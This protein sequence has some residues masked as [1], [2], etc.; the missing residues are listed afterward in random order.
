MIRKDRHLEITN[1][2]TGEI[3]IFEW[4]DPLSLRM[5]YQEVASL[6]TA[7]G[8]AKERLLRAMDETLGDEDEFNFGDGYTMKRIVSFTTKYPREV[9]AKY[10]D[11]D[12]LSLVT[13]V[14]PTKLKELIKQLADEQKL[15]PGAWK[16]IESEAEKTPKKPYIKVLKG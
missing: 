12:Q 14:N 15:E 4:K 16:A 1:T 3:F 11:E 8:V 7:L 10:L 6:I 5:V 2:L 13:D 9:V